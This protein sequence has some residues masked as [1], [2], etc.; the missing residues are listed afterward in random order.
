MGRDILVAYIA[1]YHV[2]T[3]YF[4][5]LRVLGC[6]G[7][8]WLWDSHSQRKYNLLIGLEILVLGVAVDCVVLEER[9]GE[10]CSSLR[11]ALVAGWDYSD[12][13]EQECNL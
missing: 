5:G 13:P 12:D 10:C 1:G 6:T 4:G 8:R 2:H 3:G 9:L 7:L 11:T